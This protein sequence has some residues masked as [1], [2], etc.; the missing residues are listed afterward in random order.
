MAGT[1]IR[2]SFKVEYDESELK[3]EIAAWSTSDMNPALEVANNAVAAAA[4]DS[5][6]SHIQSDV[7]DKWNPT[8]YQRTGGIIEGSAIE[9]TVGPALMII[10]HFPSG[11]SEQWKHPVDDDALIGRIE[12]GKGYEWAKHP[13]PRPYWKNFVNEMIDGVFA[14]QFDAAMSAQFGAE[15]EGGTVVERESN[16]GEY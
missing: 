5:L 14:S 12:S 3:R 7:Y 9:A 16:D 2:I 15:Y 4:K 6:R 1:G 11:A 8:V 10:E 13:G